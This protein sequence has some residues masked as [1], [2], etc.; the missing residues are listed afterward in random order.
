MRVLGS[1]DY[2]CTCKVFGS[3]I[4]SKAAAL[5]RNVVTSPHTHSHKPPLSRVRA[6]RG[7][8]RTRRI[9]RDEQMT[10]PRTSQ[11]GATTSTPCTAV[12]TTLPT[13][14][15]LQSKPRRRALIKT[16]QRAASQYSSRHSWQSGRWLLRLRDLGPPECA[17]QMSTGIVVEGLT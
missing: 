16:H 2:T 14:Q 5:G 15:S 11:G 10:S 7:W 8:F 1:S 6:W 3:R 17:V 9:C 12:M 4:S 13:E